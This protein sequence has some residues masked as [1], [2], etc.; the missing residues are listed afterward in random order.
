MNKQKSEYIRKLSLHIAPFLFACLLF[1]GV[2]TVSSPIAVKADSAA[3]V[4]ITD[5]DYQ[6]LEMKIALNGNEKVYYSDSKKTTWYEVEG[7]SVA[8]Y[9]YLDL[10]WINETSDYTMVLKGSEED[11]EVT[12]VLPERNSSFSVKYDQLEGRLVFANEDGASEFQ[13]RK[14]TSYEWSDIISMSQTPEFEETLD[15]FRASGAKIYVRIPQEKGTSA[16]NPG[17]RQSKE[18][19]VTIAKRATA[20][21]VALNVTKYTLSTKDTMEYRIHSIGGD[22]TSTSSYK[23]TTADKNMALS[24]ILP[25]DLRSSTTLLN[26]DIII[27]FRTE[28]TEKKTYSKTQYLSIAAQ[29]GQPEELVTGVSG[30]KFQIFFSDATKT[31]PYQYAIV[32][33]GE[34]FHETTASWKTITS[35]KTVSFTAKSAP[36]GTKIYV[37]MKGKSA[38]SKT[39]PVLPSKCSVYEVKYTPAAE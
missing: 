21:K 5:I 22:L 9:K 30:T 39:A 6:E 26:K 25:S 36:E 20:P 18:V 28:E 27:A 3:A 23:W 16:S 31:D 2:L 15:K 32:K 33:D 13:W 7:A 11:T 24:E 10:S 37:R 19:L 4:E 1:F 17:I 12:V 34:T 38:T 29:T 8:G 14:S 35:N